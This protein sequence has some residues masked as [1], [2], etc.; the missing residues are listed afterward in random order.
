MA[1]TGVDGTILRLDNVGVTYPGGVTAL[2]ATSIA[3]AVNDIAP[4]RKVAC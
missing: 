3:F 4:A 2:R 1:G